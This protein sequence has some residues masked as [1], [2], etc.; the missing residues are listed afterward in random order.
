MF[1]SLSSDL[2]ISNDDNSFEQTLTAHLAAIQFRSS[3]SVVEGRFDAFIKNAI[4]ETIRHNTTNDLVKNKIINLETNQMALVF[5]DRF[6]SQF[7]QK[8]MNEL[9]N[10]SYIFDNEFIQKSMSGMDVD[11]SIASLRQFFNGIPESYKDDE[12]F[13]LTLRVFN[14]ENNVNKSIVGLNADSSTEIY[15]GMEI[16]VNDDAG[17]KIFTVSMDVD[18]NGKMWYNS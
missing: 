13:G 10:T 14:T 9:K 17:V 7:A 11:L 3:Y 5:S 18:M 8:K 15:F 1:A 6:C 16:D 2:L 4:P 12:E